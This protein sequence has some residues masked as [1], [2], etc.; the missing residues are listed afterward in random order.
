MKY[1]L[2]AILILLACAAY[3]QQIVTGTIKDS[4][5]RP[6]PDVEVLI[7][8]TE[9]KSVS[10]ADGSYAI[11]VPKGYNTLKFQLYGFLS[12]EIDITAETMNIEM[13]KQSEIFDLSLEDLLSITVTTAG[14]K[15]EK[16]SD[17]PVSLVLITRKEIEI[18]GYRTLEEILENV[19]GLNL[20]DIFSW[21]GLSTGMRGYWTQYNNNMA[22]LINGDDQ[23][24]DYLDDYS[25]RQCNVPVEAIE[26]IEIVKGPMSV[27]YGS[28]AFFGA[29]NIITKPM[30]DDAKHSAVSVSYGSQNT[31]RA[32][33]ST[34]YSKK[35]FSLASS[36]MYYASDGMNISF[37]DMVAD[38]RTTNGLRTKDLDWSEM[39]KVFGISTTYKDLSLNL[40]VVNYENPQINQSIPVAGGIYRFN[41]RSTQFSAKYRKE[42][43]EKLSL[44]GK[45]G[46]GDSYAN[47]EA[48][49]VIQ[50][51]YYDIVSSYYSAEAIAVYNPLPELSLTAGLAHRNAVK[52]DSWLDSPPYMSNFRRY[53]LDGYFYSLAAF[54]QLNAK[55]LKDRLNFTAGVRLEQYSATDI[56]LRNMDGFTEEERAAHPKAADTNFNAVKH[57]PR[58]EI[59]PTPRFAAIYKITDKHIIKL[60]YNNAT[61]QASHL[62][63]AVN[64]RLKPEKQN[65]YELCYIGSLSSAFSFNLSLYQNELYH[66]V[67]RT[68]VDEKENIYKSS[69]Q[70]L[71]NT[72]GIELGMKITPFDRM[73]I[74]LDAAYQDSRNR[75]YGDAVAF[76]FSPALLA[77]AKISYYLRHN[78]FAAATANYVS[79][80]ESRWFMEDP[81]YPQGRRLGDQ[82]PAYINLCASIRI[83]DLFDT[84]FY[85]SLRAANLL[86]QEIRYPTHDFDK[87]AQRGTIGPTINFLATI[88]CSL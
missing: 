61:K 56:V 12:K 49:I 78:I 19:P 60:L 67:V 55:F 25:I 63:L 43:S 36:A 82:A 15:E 59:F 20:M 85:A 16:I 21:G 30:I 48:S 79:S 24:N 31:R 22:I 83:V 88:G 8:G 33:L 51:T 54:S 39:R 50:K 5:S 57:V 29:I 66:L 46:Y 73:A 3:S 81:L 14:K 70:G 23:K 11:V 27:I 41:R 87:W 77:Y 35:D 18:Y 1:F 45:I 72:T 42:F 6:L 74:Q 10:S 75:T 26:R 7:K 84:G 80:T 62:G 13:D 32:A 52:V 9:F 86:N 37:D 47:A 53:A 40:N 44:E 17:V 65:T 64:P 38:K 76:D 4:E 58:S 71:I 28:G 34:S 68:K 2:S 69:N